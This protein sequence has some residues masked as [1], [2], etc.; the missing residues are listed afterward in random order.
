MTQAEE[1]LEVKNLY[2]SNVP[3]DQHSPSHGEKEHQQPTNN[4]PN[5]HNPVRSVPDTIAVTNG[6]HNDNAAGHVATDG[7]SFIRDSAPP[8]GDWTKQ[9]QWHPHVYA[10]PPKQPPTP[11]SIMDILGWKGTARPKCTAESG[12]PLSVAALKENHTKPYGSLFES[13][14]K[15]SD[16]GDHGVSSFYYRP[17]DVEKRQVVVEDEDITVDRDEDSEDEV[18]EEKGKLNVDRSRP[19]SPNDEPLN[20]C[21]SKPPVEF[22]VVQ[23][24]V[25]STDA[26]MAVGRKTPSVGRSSLD[27]INE[28]KLTSEEDSTQES[29]RSSSVHYHQRHTA[30]LSASTHQQRPRSVA[31]PPTLAH[32]SDGDSDICMSND[33]SS[34]TDG[35][36]SAVNDAVASATMTMST[37]FSLPKPS[38]GSTGPTNGGTGAMPGEEETANITASHHR[39]KKKART[40]FTGR[41]IF[42]LEKQFEVKKYL[43]SNERTEM[44]KLLNVTE[45]QVKIWFQNRRTKW[46]KQDSAGG[47]GGSTGDVPSVGAISSTSHAVHSPKDVAKASGR[48][49]NVGS[50]SATTEQPAKSAW[51]NELVSVQELELH[52]QPA[53]AGG[54]SV[55]SRAYPKAGGGGGTAVK[56]GS[57]GSE[58]RRGT[59]KQHERHLAVAASSTD[60]RSSSSNS[61]SNSSSRSNSTPVEHTH[62]QMAQS[63]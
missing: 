28:R 39:R 53:P 33:D 26:T 14:T 32:S 1:V 8:S 24:G 52:Q 15:E 59:G 43:S 48:I 61:S 34:T 25:V 27:R 9:T 41:Q 54:Q 20:L 63:A 3:D 2:H 23:C 11:H 10:N 40:T 29:T 42:E 13:S 19:M 7:A 51:M 18:V 4:E 44:A 37:L 6:D 5:N 50:K 22:N 21:I 49:A 38:G 12:T 47:V 58:Q 17:T 30:A 16:G 45:T 57:S 55:K 36:F 56:K 46:K 62:Q 31:P 60:R 35:H